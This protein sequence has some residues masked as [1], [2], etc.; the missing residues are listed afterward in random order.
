MNA[1][2]KNPL[3][4]NKLLANSKNIPYDVD[5]LMAYQ[6]EEFHANGVPY[7]A[8][9]GARTAFCISADAF[10]KLSKKDKKKLMKGID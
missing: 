4:R 8:L 2:V 1:P 5:A 7:V 3:L 9:R 10:M 6:E